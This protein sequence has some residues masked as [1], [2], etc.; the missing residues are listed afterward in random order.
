MSLSSLK[1][2]DYDPSDAAQQLHEQAEQFL[3]AIET[4]KGAI[5]TVAEQA[6]LMKRKILHQRKMMGGVNAAKENEHMVQKQVGQGVQYRSDS[7][8]VKPSQASLGARMEHGAEDGQGARI[9]TFA[10]SLAP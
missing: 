4:E 5:E 1:Y 6:G 8:F 3:V 10:R 2:L 7:R 9:A